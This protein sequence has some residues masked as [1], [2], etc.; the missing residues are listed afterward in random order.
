MVNE[1]GLF[2]DTVGGSHQ[3][4]SGMVLCKLGSDLRS[5]TGSES[6]PPGFLD[7][8]YGGWEEFSW[9][10]ADEDQ[11][12]RRGLNHTWRNIHS[13][14]NGWP[15]G[16]SVGPILVV[17]GGRGQRATGGPLLICRFS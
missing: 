6:F 1:S 7:L 13:L 10:H 17:T 3:E 16:R 8:C 15:T 5:V 12:W 4:D 11:G 2:D 9:C 14:A